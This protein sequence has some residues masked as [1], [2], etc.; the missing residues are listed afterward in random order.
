MSASK[1]PI[2][3]PVPKFLDVDDLEVQALS[4][5]NPQEDVT[6]EQT[7][8]LPPEILML[9][10]DALIAHAQQSSGRVDPAPLLPSMSTCKLL[11][12]CIAPIVFREIQCSS[13]EQAS[14]WRQR[15]VDRPLLL[16]YVRAFHIDQLSEPQWIHKDTHLP[17]V[18]HLLCDHGAL[19]YLAVKI[20]TAP[21]IP[22]SAYHMEVKHALRSIT[23]RDSPL[24]ILRLVNVDVSQQFIESLGSGI[25][26]LELMG[27]TLRPSRPRS[28]PGPVGLSMVP[29]GHERMIPVERCPPL[30]GVPLGVRCITLWAS[31]IALRRIMLKSELPDLTTLYLPAHCT[32]PCMARK[33]VEELSRCA[34][35]FNR[36]RLSLCECTQSTVKY[37]D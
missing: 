5:F 19:A 4:I 16:S 30:P 34:P 23:G 15:F 22:W 27:V 9:V 31:T 12:N 37:N 11:Y 18:L 3:L 8:T 20:E 13:S 33:L 17:R 1:W 21:R 6:L 10:A 36:L 7:S 2:I 32:P 14:A 25:R 24:K 35:R 26:A 28:L 29:I